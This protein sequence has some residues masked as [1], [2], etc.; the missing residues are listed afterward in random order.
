MPFAVA[1]FCVMRCL[2]C[3]ADEA[4]GVWCRVC[5]ADAFTCLADCFAR[6]NE[7]KF[8]GDIFI[9]RRRAL[10]LMTEA[11]GARSVQCYDTLKAMVS[12]SLQTGRVSDALELL[13]RLKD[14]QLVAGGEWG[15]GCEVR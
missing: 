2:C 10:Q 13:Q 4:L 15:G 6:L 1:S 7:R 9:A 5:S 8:I 14:M 12:M 11:F 3:C